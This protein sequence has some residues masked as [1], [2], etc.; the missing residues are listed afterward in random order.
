MVQLSDEDDYN[1]ALLN[2]PWTYG[3]NYLRVYPYTLNFR[4]RTADI[5]IKAPSKDV[6][7]ALKL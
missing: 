7:F 2:G 3:T 6:F 4:A 1:N 5:A